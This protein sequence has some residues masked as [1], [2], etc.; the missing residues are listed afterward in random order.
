MAKR[1]TSTMRRQRL[2]SYVRRASVYI[3]IAAGLVGI[4]AAWFWYRSAVASDEAAIDLNTWAALT[5]G[6]SMLLQ[7][8]SAGIDAW[9]A[10]TASWA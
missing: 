4:F 6:A 3:K 5:T 7:S 8:I 2:I 9:I 10:P 1:K